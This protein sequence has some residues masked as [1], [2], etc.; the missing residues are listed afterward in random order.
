MVQAALAQAPLAQAP[1][2][3]SQIVRLGLVQ[4][5]LGAIVVLTTSTV[6]R[7]M[8]IELAL[9]AMLPGALVG[10]HYAL[11]MLRP[12]WGFGA[13]Q[14]WRITPWIIGGMAVLAIGGSLAA[15]STALMAAS[16]PLGIAVA[17]AAFTLIG[18][19]VGAAGTSL[20]ALLAK[21]VAPQRRPAAATIVWIMMIAGFAVTGITAGALLDPFSLERLVLVATGISLVALVV[22]VVAVIGIEGP[23]A[24]RE[25]VPAAQ[26]A[27]A[28]GRGSFLA[29][30]AEV[31]AE[32]KA[33]LFTIFIFVSMLAFSGQDLILEPFAGLMYDLSPGETTRLSG[34]QNGG[35]LA[36]MVTVAVLGTL[37]RED[38]AGS[39]KLWTILGC[40][41]SAFALAGIAVSGVLAPAWPIRLNIFLLGYANGAYAGA[42]IGS[43]MALAGTGAER[44]EGTRMGVWGASQ[45]IAF[46]IGGFL[47]TVAVDVLRWATG[48]SLIAYGSVF[49]VEALLFGVAA[50]LALRIARL[51]GEDPLPAP[52]R[53]ES[54]ALGAGGG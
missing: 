32:P 39:P 46:G 5:A 23:A 34:I 14:G 16:L 21:R 10:W 50:V 22:A 19:G 52:T 27:P 18:A 25:A 54:F 49:V 30:L 11:Q 38:G 4:T 15:L 37:L 33:R 26:A 7:I 8:V 3:W 40:I 1:L 36:G 44:R 9:P 51:S 6:N 2:T 45:A 53:P 35:V 42:A 41:A 47:G 24:A 28:D 29:A 13:D 20:L 31:W 17:I 48:S 43:M 12:R